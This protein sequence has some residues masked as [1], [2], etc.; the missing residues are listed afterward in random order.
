V[1]ACSS[2]TWPQ[3]LMLLRIWRLRF[4]ML[5]VVRSEGRCVL[6]AFGYGAMP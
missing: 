5:L 4:S 1:A 3:V 6:R 2:G